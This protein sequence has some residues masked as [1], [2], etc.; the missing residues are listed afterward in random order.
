MSSVKIAAACGLAA[1]V[2][3]GCGSAAKSEPGAVG[4]TP[5][6]YGR[7]KIDDPRTTHVTCMRKDGMSVLRVG[8]TGVQVGSPPAGP[9]IQ[10]LPTPGAAQQVQMSGQVQG[11]EVIGS[12]LLYPNQSSDGEL[13]KIEDCLAVGVQG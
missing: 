10:F 13:K 1:V 6:P 12:A 8:Q 9:T 2:L 3:A 7:G 4:T 11:A 5:Q